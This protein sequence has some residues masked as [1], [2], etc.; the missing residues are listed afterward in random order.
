MKEASFLLLQA[1]LRALFPDEGLHQ[2]AIYEDQ[3]GEILI[4]SSR[5]LHVLE[6]DDLTKEPRNIYFTPDCLKPFALRQQAGIFELVVETLR[7]HKF[8]LAFPDQ[9][10]AYQAMQLLVDLLTK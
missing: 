4:F 3:V 7:N 5:G 1:Q 8:I 10:D 2:L 6:E 9:T